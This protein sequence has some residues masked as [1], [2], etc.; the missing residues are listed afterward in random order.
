MFSKV[1]VANR[2]EIAI[3]VIRALKEM[4]IASAAIY[5]EADRPCR[6]VRYAEEAYC[7]GP[8]LPGKSYLRIDAIVDLATRI[9]AEAVHPGYGFLAE[10]ASFARAC[11]DAGLVF[12]GP[13]SRTIALV[14]D[15]MAARRTMA[16]AGIPV[17]PGGDRPLAGDDEIREE[18]RRIG[19]PVMMKAAAGGGGK[20]MRVVR[21]ASELAAAAKAARSEA[22][23]AFGDDRIY[24]EKLID[25]PR[26]IEFQVIAD[27]HG[28]VIHLGERECSIQR[29]HQKLVEES[30]SPVL[31]PSLREEMGKAA[32]KAVKASGY[33]NAG[34]VEFLLEG[35]RRFY[36]LEV[37]ARLQV[38]HPVTELVTGI[39]LVKEQLRVAAGEKLSRTQ[40][41]VFHQGAAIECRICAEDPE[42]NFF[43]SIGLIERLREPS[44]PG[45]RVESG[46]HVGY[47]VPIYYDPLVSKLLVWAP[48]RDEAIERMK[49]ALSEYDIEGIK[50]TIPF[51]KA[52]MESDAFRKGEFDTGFVEDVFFPKY[53]GRRMKLPE[54]AAVAAAL[55][56][57]TEAGRSKPLSERGGE[58]RKSSWRQGPGGAAWGGW[59]L[60]QR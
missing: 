32:V 57:H 23:S 50:T 37:N 31:T 4:E 11:E 10:N 48:T 30:P 16:A 2:G 13:D 56:A 21:D 35:K 19:Y 7:I 25:R 54:V 9:G 42:N 18:A 12:I 28:N 34:T 41:E 1:L 27:L 55:V 29:R 24:L 36:F 45:V 6:H 3:R 8:P 40:A 46:I 5:S 58:A 22:G 44:G 52:V 39:D 14:G 15:K 20:G 49:R 38:E 26:H 33:T 43:P 47:E 59:Q 51:H 60:H 53:A 17:V